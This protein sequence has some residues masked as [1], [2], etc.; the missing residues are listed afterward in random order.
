MA[1]GCCVVCTPSGTGD[2]ARHDETALVVRLRHPFFLARA[3]DRALSDDG[4]RARLAAAGRVE[5]QRHGWPDLAA[6]LRVGVGLE[7]GVPRAQAGTRAV[8]APAVQ[9]A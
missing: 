9:P 3:I 1:S 5:I 6:K 2:F 7:H 8:E 4:L